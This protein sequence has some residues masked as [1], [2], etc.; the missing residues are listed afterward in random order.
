M[1]YNRSPCT[2]CLTSSLLLV[3]AMNEL[4]ILYTYR[5]KR[6]E[7]Q[8]NKSGEK[9]LST[10][11]ILLKVSFFPYLFFLSL[12]RACVVYCFVESLQYILW[13]LLIANIP[14]IQLN[15]FCW[16]LFRFGLLVIY[17]ELISKSVC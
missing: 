2:G 7:Y 16:I 13:S 8:R 9:S 4:C 11:L 1:T 10:I 6:L 17:F 5:I 3:F 14:E 12:S 15:L